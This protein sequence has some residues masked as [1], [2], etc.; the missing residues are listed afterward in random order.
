VHNLGTKVPLQEFLDAAEST[1]ADAIGM[2][3]LLVKSTLV[4]RE[5]LEA[6]N[7]RNLANYPVIL[8]GAA[9][10]RTYVERDLREVYDGQ[11]FYGKDAFD[12][13]DVVKRL[14]SAKQRGEV[15]PGFGREVAGRDLP[16]RSERQAAEADEAARFVVPPTV[17]KDV[18][19]PTP[20]FLGSRVATGIG[21]GEIVEWINETALFR[22]QWQFRPEAGEDDAAS[23]ERLRPI[24][25]EHLDTAYDRRVLVPAP[26]WGY[27]PVNADGN[28]LVVRQDD[29]RKA[30][31]W[32]R[33]IR[34]EWGIADED[35]AALAGIFRQ[36]F[37][38]GRYSWGYPACP[39]QED[40][41]KVGDLVEMGRIGVKLGEEYQLEPEQSTSAIICHHP[42]AKYFVAR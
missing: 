7:E 41:E 35:G 38:G 27:F 20:P 1:Q 17:A 39:N 2:S 11:V 16:R 26:A 5:N 34:E 8:G 19:V 23:K 31:R 15:A 21:L 28:D 13:L 40:Q 25:R 36:R 24:L 3:G 37:R 22:N 32:H 33:R 29:D 14:M 4:M 10:N 12:G 9:L 18:P 30:E 6:M 42:A